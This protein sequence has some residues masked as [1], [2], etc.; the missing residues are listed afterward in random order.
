[1]EQLHYLS[2][3]EA[4]MR[5]AEFLV[6]STDDRGWIMTPMDEI[7]EALGHPIEEVEKVLRQPVVP[8]DSQHHVPAVPGEFV[9]ELYPGGR[10]TIR[11]R[12]TSASRSPR[13][14]A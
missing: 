4:S 3:P 1:M 11:G 10:R 13:P 2:L 9:R 8:S 5:I 14:T 12:A 7:A 6:G